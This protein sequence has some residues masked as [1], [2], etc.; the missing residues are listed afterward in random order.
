MDIE[1]LKCEVDS[2]LHPEAD[3]DD[4]L[5]WVSPHPRLASVH[6]LDTSYF[7]GPHDPKG[8]SMF[9]RLLNDESDPLHKTLES[10][11]VPLSLFTA[12][13]QLFGDSLV[14]Y[15]VRKKRWDV[16]RFYPSILMTVWAAFESWVRIS[17]EVLVAV[18]PTLPTVIKHALL[19]KREI[20]DD[21]GKFRTRRD[22]KPVLMRYWL[23]L[24]YGCNLEWERGSE[25]WQTAERAREVRD[26]LV[27][28][29]IQG[30]PALT[31]SE[32]WCHMEAVLM[33]FIGP[34]AKIRRTIFG[35]QYDLY[36]TLAALQPLITQ[37][38]ERPFHKGWP[39]D[40]TFFDCPFDGVDDSKYPRRWKALLQPG[41]ANT[42]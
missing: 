23:V 28:Y 19:E 7:L 5:L 36:S 10:A 41:K 17:S 40:A 6:K 16:Y 26:S 18:V 12:G 8:D 30:A 24:K 38:E 35:P 21:S 37:F 32:I 25:M 13:L 39:K 20:I 9:T 2:I 4:R 11:S 34:S 14:E 22:F 42:L 29:N 31:S 3:E 33:L 27:H 15:H 1:D